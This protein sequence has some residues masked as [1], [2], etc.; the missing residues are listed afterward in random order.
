MQ[1]SV[2][3]SAAALQTDGWTTFPSNTQARVPVWE[4]DDIAH[5][6]HVNASGGEVR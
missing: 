1:Q 3:S 5:F 2:R 6:L 4:N